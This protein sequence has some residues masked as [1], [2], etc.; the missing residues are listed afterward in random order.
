MMCFTGQEYKSRG[1]RH[2]KDVMCSLNYNSVGCGW[3][4]DKTGNTWK[5]QKQ[6][7][8]EDSGRPNEKE[9]S[10]KLMLMNAGAIEGL[11]LL[12]YPQIQTKHRQ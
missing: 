3:G 12:K 6:S 7:I 4:P 2:R 9:A 1:D 8:R 10:L 11:R 5:R